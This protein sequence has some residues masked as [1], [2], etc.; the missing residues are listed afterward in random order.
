M[1]FVNE[2]IPAEVIE[3]FNPDVIYQ[4]AYR[5]RVPFDGGRWTIDRERQTFL[6]C[7]CGGGREREI[8]DNYALIC[9]DNITKFEATSSLSG[10]KIN[11]WRATWTI[12][13]ITPP[14]EVQGEI[15]DF[16]TLIVECLTARGNST[17]QSDNITEVVVHFI[18][19]YD[20]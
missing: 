10:D 7:L 8:P 3:A 17:G 5:H 13:K 15:R 4:G 19:G 9:G 18:N 6:L 20:G 11:G 2:D 1:P 14:I 12:S 16:E